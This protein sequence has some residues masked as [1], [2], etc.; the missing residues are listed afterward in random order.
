MSV[1]AETYCLK[2]I[3]GDSMMSYLIYMTV[4]LQEMHRLLKPTGSIWLHCDPTAGHY[5]KVVMDAVFGKSNFRNDVVWHYYNKYAAGKRAFGRNYDTL[6]FYAGKDAAFTPQREE[7]EAP[8]KQLIRENVGGVLRNKRGPD[9]KV[10]YRTV[11]DRKVDAVW[12]I[13][14]LQ[15]A[16]K[17]RIG[18]PTQKPLALLRRIV[19]T[20]SRPGDMVLDPFCG[21]ATACIAAEMEGRRWAGIDISPKAAD[22]V[23]LRMAREMPLLTYRGT[24]RTDI[25]IRTDL[26]KLPPADGKDNKEAM[27][28]RQEGYCAA[29]AEYFQLR[30]LTVDHV[31]SRSRGGS[32]HISNLQLL[33][34]ACNSMKGDR[35]ME[36][37][38][39]RLAELDLIDEAQQRRLAT[40]RVQD[41]RT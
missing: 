35:P 29:C 22:L 5:L 19:R 26:G 21:C 7:R 37:L 30:N 28:E 2:A 40:A 16:A 3:H 15:P 25:P 11:T 24:H 20:S 38:A 32:D 27:Y 13:P 8:V 12:R 36:Y 33:C 39:R 10:M 6:L 41:L 17:E 14:C 34:G 31:V 1:T 9:G 23:K 4:R 18:Y